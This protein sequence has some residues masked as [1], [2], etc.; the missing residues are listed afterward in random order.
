MDHELMRWFEAEHLPEELRS[1]SLGC[2]ELACTIEAE[3]PSCA[4][5]TAGLR[6]LLEAKDCFVRA[7][8]LEREEAKVKAAEI[9]PPPAPPGPPAT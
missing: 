2:A 5:K 3:L 1:V 7:K 9:P 4:E 6:K 8:I